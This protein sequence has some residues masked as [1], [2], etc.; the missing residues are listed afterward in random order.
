MS[1]TLSSTNKDLILGFQAKLKYAENKIKDLRAQKRAEVL[2]TEN[3]HNDDMQVINNNYD[4]QITTIET[5]IADL[6][7][8]L[9]AIK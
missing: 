9:E 1:I 7:N 5:D 4:P 8:Q 3:T 6:N 2:T